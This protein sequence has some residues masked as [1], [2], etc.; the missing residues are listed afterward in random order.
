M[1]FAFC[2]KLSTPK[3]CFRWPH[4]NAISNIITQATF[5][6]FRCSR[7]SFANSGS[8]AA[9]RFLQTS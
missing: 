4:V 2:G 5:E 3:L 7:I 6:R 1:L 9:A 8:A